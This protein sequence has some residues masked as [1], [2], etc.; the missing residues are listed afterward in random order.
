M[1][2]SITKQKKKQ[3]KKNEK[4]LLQNPKGKGWLLVDL[5]YPQHLHKSH[6]DYPLAP[7][8]LA[9]KKEWLSES[10]TEL[11]ENNSMLNIQKLG[12]NLIDKKKYVVHYR[13]LQL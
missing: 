8:K 5:E 11:L 1:K 4:Y 7:K 3:K 2:K 6:N 9:V 13:N 12:P 10:K